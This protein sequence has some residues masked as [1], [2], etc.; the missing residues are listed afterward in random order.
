MQVGDEPGHDVK[1]ALSSIR[2]LPDT[3]EDAPAVTERKC[4]IADRRQVETGRRRAFI[5]MAGTQV[6]PG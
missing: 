2:R 6:K 1:A 4:S 5:V 3:H